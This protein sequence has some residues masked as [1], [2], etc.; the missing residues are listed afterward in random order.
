MHQFYSADPKAFHSANDLSAVI[1]NFGFYKGRYLASYPKSF[2]RDIFNATAHLPEIE[3]ARIRS[4]LQKNKPAIFKLGVAYDKNRTWEENCLQLVNNQVLRGFVF[5]GEAD[6]KVTFR[7]E[8]VIDGELP[9]ADGLK[10]PSTAT[11]LVD[12]MSPIIRS[13]SEVYLIDPYFSLGKTK[14][15][16]FMQELLLRPDSKGIH[17]LLF[18]K[19]EHFATKE[20]VSVLSEQLLLDHLQDECQL[21][22]Y[23]L[24]SMADMHGRY[25]FTIYG[26]ATYDKGFQVAKHTIVDLSVM[27]KG[28][29]TEYFDEYNSII[30]QINPVYTLKARI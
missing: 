21:S 9:S 28:L 24:D 13:S 27:P 1:N 30:H 3:K 12:Y 11:N 20:S 4:L 16:E 22:F 19:A 15:I 23:P 10:V 26:G 2:I 18:C 17:F 25:V 8:D 6:N 5:D 29:H 7:V 14:Y